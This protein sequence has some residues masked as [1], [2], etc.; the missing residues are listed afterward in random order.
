MQLQEHPS[1][2]EVPQEFL[3]N[4]EPEQDFFQTGFVGADQSN[5]SRKSK[6]TVK[7]KKKK[8]KGSNIGDP[9]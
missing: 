9:S 7:K 2:P 5:F 1:P 6:K 4:Q 8:K 3:E